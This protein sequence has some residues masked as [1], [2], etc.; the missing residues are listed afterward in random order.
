KF[1]FRLTPKSSNYPMPQNT[2]ASVD[3]KTGAMTVSRLEQVMYPSEPLPSVWTMWER[4]IPT[5]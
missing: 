5:R 2:S 3:K 4:P 1:S